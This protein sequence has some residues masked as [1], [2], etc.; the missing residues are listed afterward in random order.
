MPILIL[1]SLTY[2][3][4]PHKKIPQQGYLIKSEFI[5]IDHGKETKMEKEF[6]LAKNNK[7]WTTLV[8]TKNGLTLLGRMV[9]SDQKTIEMEYILLDTKRTHSV[10]STPSIAALLGEQSQIGLQTDTEQ[11]TIK[12][13]AKWVDY[14]STQKPN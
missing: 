3:A 14:T 8:P 12:L 11:S 2:A 6:I 5:H 13:F 7:S 1:S 10:L 4:I 9:K